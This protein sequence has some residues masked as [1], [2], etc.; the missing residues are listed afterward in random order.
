MFS[1]V[2]TDTG[3]RHALARII[4]R[5]VA[6]VVMLCVSTACLAAS[7]SGTAPVRHVFIIVL[8]NESYAVTFG[9]NSLAPYLAHE[10]PKQGALL[11]HYYGIGHYSLDNYVAMISGQ[12]PNAATQNDC[13]IYSEF[14][15][16]ATKPDANG[17]WPG[18]GCV[19]PKNVPTI[20]DQLTTA[21][22]SWKAYMED[23]GADPSRESATCGH[24][25]IGADD[26]TRHATPKDQYAAKH[27]PFVYFH[28]IID[29]TNY[30]GTHV[31]NLDALTND[32]A[33]IDTTPNYV[34]ITPNLCH[35]GH[36]AP[37]QNGEQGGLISADAFL[38]TWVPRILNSPA[39]QKDGLL[40][41]TFDEGTDAVAC[42]N[43]KGLPGG[44]QPGQYG[45]GGGQI[46]AV[47]ISPFIAP[48]TTSTVPYNH[49]N[50]LR[51]IEDFFG[52]EH[53][54][55]AGAKHLRT[56]GSDVF[57]AHPSLSK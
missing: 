47:L 33:H 23:M 49:Y 11:P 14:V 26:P 29:D 55:Y 21:G 27:N 22:L 46:G 57:T 31:V 56:F 20:A 12:A 13:T 34:Y 2:S 17:Q 50:L 15:A 25:A 3:S 1:Y 9:Q 24:V 45:P 10:L 28:S 54:G 40:V 16:T 30:C 41:I 18:S 51:S 52:L 42:C 53:L 39:F 19:Y 43:E 35:D 38:R 6:L 8:E 4:P 32:L 44:P 37:C 7:T 36:D 48:G 5:L